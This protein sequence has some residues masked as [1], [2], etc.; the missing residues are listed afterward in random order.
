MP[1]LKPISTATPQ[2]D[3]FSDTAQWALSA[4]ARSNAMR[5]NRSTGE[6]TLRPASARI[7]ET[8][9]PTA[10]PLVMQATQPVGLDRAMSQGHLAADA[11]SDPDLCQPYLNRQGPNTLSQVAVTSN[12]A[13]SSPTEKEANDL[14]TRSIAIVHDILLDEPLVALVASPATDQFV[15]VDSS[16]N[17]GLWRASSG[18]LERTLLTDTI[19]A[20]VFSRDGSAL[21]AARRVSEKTTRCLISIDRED[22]GLLRRMERIQSLLSPLRNRHR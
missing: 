22:G 21:L 1:R 10:S 16:S 8:G 12:D 9:R 20:P 6:W 11:P 17:S 2:N 3:H 7:F 18:L 4:V 5:L 15:T 19:R 13:G 14:A